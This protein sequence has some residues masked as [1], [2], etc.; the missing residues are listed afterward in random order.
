MDLRLLR[1][2]LAV[3]EELHFGRAAARLFIAQ[4]SLSK[5]I[6]KLEH[7]LGVQLLQR[8]R[9]SVELTA[10]GRALLEDGPTLLARVDALAERVRAVAAGSHG[11]LRIGFLAWVRDD[12]VTAALDAFRAMRPGVEVS[13]REIDYADPLGLLADHSVDV[14]ITSL[15]VGDDQYK[16]GPV[17]YEAP[18][19]LAVPRTHPLA[20]RGDTVAVE[21]LAEAELLAP[22]AAAPDW[23]INFVAPPITPSGRPIERG[24]R[25]ASLPELLAAVGAGAG[26]SLTT[27]YIA[28]H[29]ARTDILFLPVAD[30]APCRLAP[31]WRPDDDNPLIMPF[32]DVLSNVNRDSIV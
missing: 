10:A 26:I 23:W 5:Q 9:R 14:L 16:V 22:V 12:V 7:D 17:F 21:D 8:D 15:P 18:R 3:A 24:A 11:H 1:Y 30:A 29:V 6:R 25:F 13:L 27:S 32:L 2:F 19:V 31:V 4:P 20:A 28:E